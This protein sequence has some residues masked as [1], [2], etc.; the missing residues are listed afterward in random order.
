MEH[1]IHLRVKH[2]SIINSQPVPKNILK[3]IQRG[4]SAFI[5][6]IVCLSG[7]IHAKHADMHISSE[8]G[9][10]NLFTFY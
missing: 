2:G 5:F 4:G 10:Q 6:M 9:L 7:Q 1:G 8:F 3:S